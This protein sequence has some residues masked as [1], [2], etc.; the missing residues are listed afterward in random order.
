M[1]NERI[2]NQIQ[3]YKDT[4]FPILRYKKQVRYFLGPVQALDETQRPTSRSSKGCS[5]YNPPSGSRDTVIC[6]REPY[7]S[8]AGSEKALICSRKR[9]SEAAACG[10]WVERSEGG[11]QT[12][13]RRPG[14]SAKRDVG[15]S[16][17]AGVANGVKRSER[18]RGQRPLKAE[19]RRTAT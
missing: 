13:R 10:R 9:F 11:P 17:A 4:I 14:R 12:A 3:L 8:L 6:A 18:I 19:K 5:K 1:R 15:R 7:I 16:G 2:G